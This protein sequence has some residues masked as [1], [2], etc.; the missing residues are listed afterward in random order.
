MSTF[1]VPQLR[2]TLAYDLPPGVRFQIDAFD[3]QHNSPL[4]DHA[5]FVNLLPEP[6]M[7]EAVAW[8]N[9]ARICRDA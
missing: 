3:G 2:L 8:L 9:E 5:L 1:P 6:L 4:T 7:P